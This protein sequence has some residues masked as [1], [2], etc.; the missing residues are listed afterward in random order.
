MNLPITKNYLFL[1]LAIFLAL[2]AGSCKKSTAQENQAGQAEESGDN[3]PEVDPVYWVIEGLR[4]REEPKTNGKE[5]QTM[6]R[7]TMVTK[8]DTGNEA[9]INNITDNWLYVQTEDQTKGW[10]FGGYLADVKEKAVIT[11]YWVDVA[12]DR[13][14]LNFNADGVYTSGALQAGGKLGSR[15]YAS[16]IFGTWSYAGGDTIRVDVTGVNNKEE[17]YSFDMPFSIIDTDKVKFQDTVYRRMNA[18]ELR[19]VGVR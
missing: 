3:E 11:G 2:T 14:I 8:L 6:Q 5:I 10:C 19:A 9:T 1:A 13:L 18:Q 15:L 12:R 4:L 17:E 7:G 16:G